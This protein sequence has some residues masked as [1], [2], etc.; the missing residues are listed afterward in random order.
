MWYRVHGFIIRWNF[1]V[2]N[3]VYLQVSN[4]IV[5]ASKFSRNPKP[6]RELVKFKSFQNFKHTC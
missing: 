3:Y 1:I 5:I 4:L 2:S 6:A